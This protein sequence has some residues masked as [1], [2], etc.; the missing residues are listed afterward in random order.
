MDV[1]TTPESRWSV[2][3]IGYVSTPRAEAIDDGWGDEISTITLRQ[4]MQ[5]SSLLGITEFSHIEVIY[6]F[7]GVE[8]KSVHRGSRVPRSNPAWPVVGILAQRAKDRPNRLG[9]ATCELLDVSGRT[10][11]VRGLDAI[12]GTP[13]L[14]IKPYMVEFG[15]RSP[16][17]QPQW[18]H[19]LMANY[20]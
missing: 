7:H 18:S 16:V 8:P 20:Y 13:V 5:V 19:E 14:D 9:L 2:S 3:A 10:I 15:P 17:R 12:D 4:P 11:R 6:L 1:A